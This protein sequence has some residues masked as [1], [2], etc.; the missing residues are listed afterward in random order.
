MLYNVFGCAA[1][2]CYNFV[3]LCVAVVYKLKMFGLDMFIGNFVLKN[4]HYKVGSLLLLDSFVIPTIHCYWI[5][6]NDMVYIL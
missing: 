1:F 2:L 6:F 3:F 4:G 5:Q